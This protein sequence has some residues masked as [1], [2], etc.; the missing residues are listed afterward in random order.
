MGVIGPPPHSALTAPHPSLPGRSQNT[1]HREGDASGG[2]WNFRTVR[3][4]P[5]ENP[6]VTPLPLSPVPGCSPVREGRWDRGGVVVS[7]E[8]GSGCLSVVL[9]PPVVVPAGPQTTP[10]PT[11]PTHPPGPRWGPAGPPTPSL[12]S[13][14]SPAQHKAG[15][16][17]G[18]SAHW[19]DPTAQSVART[20]A[21]TCDARPAHAPPAHP[22]TP[23]EIGLRSTC[24]AHC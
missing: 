8:G 10:Q 20:S 11:P 15:R 22:P 9:R 18:G 17:W 2:R 4:L 13:D 3:S 1:P 23:P 16:Y 6:P 12:P 7:W 24:D 14:P 21:R 19:L 5:S